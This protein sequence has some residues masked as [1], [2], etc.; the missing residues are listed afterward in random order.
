[1]S[2]SKQERKT[3]Q[4]SLALQRKSTDLQPDI[5]NGER[6][7]MREQSGEGA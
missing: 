7:G 5:V 3:K 6:K 4:M 1:M 2:D